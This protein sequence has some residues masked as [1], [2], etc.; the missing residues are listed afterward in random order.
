[1]GSRA[2][3]NASGEDGFII[4]E[5][6]VSALIL[7]IVAG[8]VLT[9]IAATTRGAAV[10][11]DRAVANDLAQA[12]QA[13]MRTLAISEI[14]AEPAREPVV[15]GTKYL[16]QSK[17]EFVN[18][19]LDA[20]ACASK[21]SPPD[22]VQLTTTVSS[23]SMVNPV[24][25]QSVVSPSTGS[26]DKNKGTITAKTAN[27]VGQPLPGISVGLKQLPSGP[28]R[29]GTTGSEGCVNFVSV[30]TETSY[31]VTYSSTS[32]VNTQGEGKSSET[33]KLTEPYKT[34]PASPSLWDS[35]VT[36][37]PKFRYLDASGKLVVA[38]A[39]TMYVANTTNSYEKALGTPGVV[40]P[41]ATPLSKVVFPFKSPSEYVAFAGLCPTNNPG[42]STANKVGLYSG[43]VAPGATLEPVIQMP[44]LDVTVTTKSGKEGKEGTEQ[45]VSG[46][47]LTVTDRNCKYSGSNIKRTYMTNSL[48]HI[49]GEAAVKLNP[50][51]PTEPA[52]LPFGTYEICA[53]ATINTEARYAMVEQKVEGLTSKGTEVKLNVQKGTAC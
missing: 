52:V 27:A 37:T 6:L 18:H 16:I 48:G 41:A 12:D 51:T 29:S 21:E 15:N 20:V 14:T 40:P 25:L 34:V 28:T 11:R 47:K 50:A 23:Q 7:A 17:R 8:A 32:L 36:I 2:R 3:K 22:Y 26:L 38:P 24:V 45:L 53:S 46:A 30:P 1:M 13:R 35:P 44:K 10:Q 33:F 19:Q 9:L 39:D 31:E 43:V 4:I 42:T 49:A 5:V